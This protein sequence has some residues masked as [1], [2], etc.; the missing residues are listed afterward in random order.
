MPRPRIHF[1]D[2]TAKGWKATKHRKRQREK[3]NSR[4]AHFVEYKGN[5]C[6]DCKQTFPICCYDFHHLDETKK[7]FEIAPG[8]DRE[9]GVLTEEVD[10]CVML[11]SNCH[12]IRHS[13]DSPTL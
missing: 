6:Y 9:I 2:D 11:C 8:L 1:D 7:S 13:I 12:R 10:K 3:R 4:K 5:K